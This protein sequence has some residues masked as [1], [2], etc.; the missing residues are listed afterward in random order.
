MYPK[1]VTRFFDR[2]DYNEV[3]KNVEKDKVNHYMVGFQVIKQYLGTIR[4]IFNMK[5]LQ[6]LANI[7]KSALTTNRWKNFIKLVGKRK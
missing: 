4:I 6:G 2:D 5:K 7:E 3:M 1:H